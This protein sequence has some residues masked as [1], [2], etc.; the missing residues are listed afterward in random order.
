MAFKSSFQPYPL[1]DS[2]ET[3]WDELE[4]EAVVPSHPSLLPKTVSQLCSHAQAGMDC[5]TGAPGCAH[6]TYRGRMHLKAASSPCPLHRGVMG[7]G[8]M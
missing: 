5:V 3:Q 8:P 1:F 7:T 4:M 2:M 6:P